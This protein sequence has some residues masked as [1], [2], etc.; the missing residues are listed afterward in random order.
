MNSGKIKSVLIF[1]VLIGILFYFGNL[2]AR[3]ST[4]S[5]EDT[6]QSARFLGIVA[7]LQD[8]AFD[9]DFV[10][11]L[12]DTAIKTDV[13]VQ[14]LSSSD[15][16]RD[17]PFRKSDPSIL[18]ESPQDVF[19][20]QGEVRAIRE[21]L[22]PPSPD[23]RLPVEDQGVAVPSA[24]EFVEQQVSVPPTEGFVEEQVPVDEKLFEESVDDPA[25]EGSDLPS[26]TL[27]R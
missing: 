20:G 27:T 19:S 16:G 7:V 12:G 21:V 14:P 15:F 8:I 25:G 2:I 23:I 11:S 13:Y 26:A 22:P 24:E 9:L 5:I 3:E 4:F 18:F 17:N 10:N 1:I 6:E